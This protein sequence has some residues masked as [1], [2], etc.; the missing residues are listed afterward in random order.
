MSKSKRETFLGAV[1][2]AK[3]VPSV[4]TRTEHKISRQKKPRYVILVLYEKQ[5]KRS[6]FAIVG[7]FVSYGILSVS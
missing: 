5:H 7:D 4:D 1:E 3:G 2:L 6:L